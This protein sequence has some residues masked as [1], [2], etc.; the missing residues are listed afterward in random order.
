MDQTSRDQLTCDM[1]YTDYEMYRCYE[2]DREMVGYTV[3]ILCVRR[4][5]GAG[6]FKDNGSYRPEDLRR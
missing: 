3:A 1:I 5:K 6:I 2:V 4:N